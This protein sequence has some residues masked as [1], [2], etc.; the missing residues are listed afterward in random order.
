MTKTQ[1]RIDRKVNA[2]YRQFL[3]CKHQVYHYLIE[4]T[5]HV[6]PRN[7]DV[8]NYSSCVPKAK[9]RKIVENAITLARKSHH[10]RGSQSFL[11]IAWNDIEKKISP[12]ID[13][14]KI[15]YEIIMSGYY[16]SG[17]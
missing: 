2:M 1:E 14:N 17:E 8:R 10:P 3:R 16:S 5:D 9:T 7:T 12:F 11:D 4:I 15:N 13:H 6:D